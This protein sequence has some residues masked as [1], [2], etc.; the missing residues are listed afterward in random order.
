M[1]NQIYV[2]CTKEYV[3]TYCK[4]G[5]LT[6]MVW[7]TSS[8]R[9]E[10]LLYN[11]RRYPVLQKSKCGLSHEELL[12]KDVIQD[13]SFNFKPQLKHCVLLL[14]IAMSVLLP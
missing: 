13:F 11:L 8:L 10:F 5:L 3:K 14:K 1:P 6:D 9:L 4:A 2:N 12:T 7:L